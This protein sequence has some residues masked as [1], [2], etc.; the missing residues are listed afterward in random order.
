MTLECVRC[1]RCD[2]DVDIQPIEVSGAVGEYFRSRLGRHHVCRCLES[3]VGALM[4]WCS[5]PLLK[6]GGWR[7]QNDR[8]HC[9]GDEFCR[10]MSENASRKF[11][12]LQIFLASEMSHWASDTSY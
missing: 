1:V 8:H 9:R 4:E 12:K 5:T 10:R 11:P 2:R 3:R 6:G 7:T